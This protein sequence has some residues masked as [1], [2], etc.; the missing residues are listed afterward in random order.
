ME[1]KFSRK[2]KSEP[3]N[4][5]SFKNGDRTRSISSKCWFRRKSSTI[6]LQ[7]AV[8]ARVWHAFISAV[9][10]EKQWLFFQLFL[11]TWTCRRT[12]NL[13]FFVNLWKSSKLLAVLK[14]FVES[15]YMFSITIS[16]A[17]LWNGK[18]CSGS[19]GGANCQVLQLGDSWIVD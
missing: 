17:V 18:L 14:I 2:P 6:V 5:K 13:R 8:A 15:S 11:L 3:K 10:R 16:A 9:S 12:C 19:L 4:F 1:Y 7:T